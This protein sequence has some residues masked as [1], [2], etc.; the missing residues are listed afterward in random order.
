MYIQ[1]FKE[2][3]WFSNFVFASFY[4]SISHNVFGFNL[5]SVDKLQN[6][7]RETNCT[8][9]LTWFYLVT[10]WWKNQHRLLDH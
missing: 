7:C 6:S 4:I 9:I 3:L 8:C 10:T 2:I 1:H 5:L